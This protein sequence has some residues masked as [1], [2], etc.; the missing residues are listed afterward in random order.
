[1]TAMPPWVRMTRCGD[2]PL[3]TQAGRHRDRKGTKS[4]TLSTRRTGVETATTHRCV[5]V[6]SCVVQCHEAGRPVQ[7]NRV[8]FS[9]AG[10]ARRAPPLRTTIPNQSTDTSRGLRQRLG[11]LRPTGMK[12]EPHFKFSSGS[13]STQGQRTETG[14]YEP[15]QVGDG[16]NDLGSQGAAEAEPQSLRY[17]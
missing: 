3:D 4:Y 17:P 11:G 14:E 16:G 12:T 7:V 1:M 6:V 8:S 9:A 15:H 10:A 5:G 2:D 13:R